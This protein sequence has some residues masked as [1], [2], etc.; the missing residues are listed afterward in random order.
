[1]NRAQHLK[2]DLLHDVVVLGVRSQEAPHQAIDVLGEASMERSEASL[3]ILKHT[4]H[5]L[6]VEPTLQLS[7]LVVED[8]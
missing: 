5:E 1:M 8:A 3:G 2:K 6:C 7:L 4:I